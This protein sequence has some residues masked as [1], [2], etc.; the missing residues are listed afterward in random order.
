MKMF[1]VSLK[2][3]DSIALHTHPNHS[4]Y[5]IEGGKIEVNIEGVG[6]RIMDLQP[7]TGWIGGPLTDFG[8]NIGTTN[9]KWVE[10]DVYGNT[11]K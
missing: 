10:T 3:G 6:K 1:E 8:K 4:F 9:V 7:G 5:V 11:V 2:P